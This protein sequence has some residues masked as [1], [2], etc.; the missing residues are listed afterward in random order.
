MY[1]MQFERG[2]YAWGRQAELHTQ[3]TELIARATT[4]SSLPADADEIVGD[5]YLALLAFARRCRDT[6][7]ELA[8]GNDLGPE[9]SIDKILLS[10]AEQTMTETR[11][12]GCCWPRLELA[13]RRRRQCGA[14]GGVAGRTR[15]SPRSTAAPARCSATS[16]PS[17]CSDCPEDDERLR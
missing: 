10:S 9:I 15:A 3:L 17:G 13:E 5:A 12:G 4:R 11:C 7:G 14:G 16:S 6:I 8:A 1:L 2:A